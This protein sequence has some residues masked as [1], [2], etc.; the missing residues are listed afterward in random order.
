MYTNLVHSE[1]YV[2]FPFRLSMENEHHIVA[3]VGEEVMET[4]V[5]QKY[6]IGDGIF[7]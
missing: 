4:Q 5:A 1:I 7:N 6:N 2:W 3:P